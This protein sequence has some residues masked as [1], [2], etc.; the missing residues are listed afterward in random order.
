[1]I[2][3]EIII[4]L[5]VTIY[6]PQYYEIKNWIHYKNHLKNDKNIDFVFLIDN[7]NI[8]SNIIN[9]IKKN[10][11]NYKIFDKNYGKFY[12]VKD[13]IDKN[14]IK[15]EFIKICDPDDLISMHHLRKLVKKLSLLKKEKDYLILTKHGY[16]NGGY[17]STRNIDVTKVNMKIL[18]TVP[19][20]YN[21]IISTRVIKEYKEKYINLTKSSDSIFAIIALSNKN[22]LFITMEN[23]W[24][25]VYNKRKGIS[26]SFNK[27]NH[28]KEKLKKDYQKLF[29]DTFYYLKLSEKIKKEINSI[30]Y[31]SFPRKFDFYTTHNALIGSK[32][33]LFK[34]IKYTKQIYKIFRRIDNAEGEWNYL[35]LLKFILLQIFKRKIKV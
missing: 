11:A 6:D 26:N 17:Y 35:I 1:M 3:E 7:P 5:A 12:I 15:G 19:V 16:I 14:I 32:F 9:L 2:N 28:N 22:C 20:N 33:F 4:T 21:T 34:R 13:A 10:N 31:T 8:N 18:R 30:K 25:Y 24:F 27:F 29:F 23:D